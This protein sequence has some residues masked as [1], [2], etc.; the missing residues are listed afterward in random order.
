[1][2]KISRFS[3]LRANF[4][5]SDP[6]FQ[7]PQTF[8]DTVLLT[9]DWSGGG[10]ATCLPVQMFGTVTYPAL[11]AGA[12]VGALLTV[13]KNECWRMIGAGLAQVVGTPYIVLGAYHPESAYFVPLTDRHQAVAGRVVP[14][15]FCRAAVIPPG[16]VFAFQSDTAALNDSFT[17]NFLYIPGAAG[18]G[19]T[20]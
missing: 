1:M 2:P 11:P 17:I 15:P 19:F 4:L 12:V 5:P 8:Y 10:L 13:S 14:I 6:G 9:Q 18:Q 7:S 3:D 20:F 16:A